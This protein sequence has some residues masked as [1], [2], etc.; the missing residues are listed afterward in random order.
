MVLHFATE[1]V[2]IYLLT[3]FFIRVFGDEFEARRF[4]RRV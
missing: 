4:E 2:P 1:D 3:Y